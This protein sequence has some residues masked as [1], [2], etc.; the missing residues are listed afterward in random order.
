[1]YRAYRKDN[2]PLRSGY[3]FKKLYLRRVQHEG[4]L[5]TV[6]DVIAE[7]NSKDDFQFKCSCAIAQLKGES[8]LKKIA[9]NGK[10]VDASEVADSFP[11]TPSGKL[12]LARFRENCC[13]KTV[14]IHGQLVTPESVVNDFLAIN[15]RLELARFRQECCER[16][17]PINGRPVSTKSVV[18]DFLAINAQLELARFKQ[19]CCFE[20]LPI[21]GQQVST[22]EVIDHT[23]AAG[24]K[25]GVICFRR[26]C[27]FRELPIAGQQVTPESVLNGFQKLGA[28]LEVARFLEECYWKGISVEHGPVSAERVADS[29]QVANAHLELA[30]FRADCCLKG[31]LLHNH[32]VSP[33]VV[34]DSFPAN[35][36]G[37]SALARFKVKCCLDGFLLHGRPISPEE[38]FSHFPRHQESKMV[39]AHFLEECFLRN[40][41]V[42]GQLV[43]AESVLLS[44]PNT[45]DGQTSLARFRE[46][47]CLKGL[48]ISG[49]LVSPESVMSSFPDNRKG[50]ISRARFTEKCAIRGLWLFGQPI[51]THDVLMGYPD[52]PEGR[53]AAGRFQEDCLFK[54]LM[55]R[56][57]ALTAEAVF[58]ALDEHALAKA[59]FQAECCLRSL[60]LHGRP[61][62]PDTVVAAYPKN[63]D[64]QKQLSHFKRQCCLNNLP[65]AG[66][67]VQP[68]PLVYELE[69]KNMLLE[70]ACFYAELALQA[71]KLNGKELSNDQVLDAFNQLK[72]DYSIKKVY[73]LMQRLIALPELDHRQESQATFEQAWQI[74]ADNPLKDERFR[75]QRCVLLFLAMKHALPLADQPV[76]P[77]TVWQS[78]TALRDSFGNTRLQ[79]YF[80]ADCYF[81]DT[82][83]DGQPVS[84]QQ[85]LG[86]LKKLLPGRLR[87][88]LSCWFEELCR[89]PCKT[90]T[91]NRVLPPPG[92]AQPRP[93]RRP[94][95]IDVH[96]KGRYTGGPFP[97]EVVEHFDDPLR[98][99]PTLISSQTRKAL[100][101]IRGMRGLCLTGSFSRWLQG[102]GSSFNDIDMMASRETITTLV[103]HLTKQLGNQESE[104]DISCKV[105]AREAPGCPQLHL[106]PMVTITLSE[107]DLGQKVSVLQASVYPPD[108]IDNLNTITAAIP[109]EHGTISCLTYVAEVK[110]LND[111]LHFL[112]DQLDDLTTQLLSGPGFTIPRTILFNYPQHRQECVFALLMRC[113]LTLNKAKQFTALLACSDPAALL[114]ELRTRGR[115]LH[116]RLLGHAHR[117]PFIAAL[118]HWLARPS[119]RNTSLDNKRTFIRSLLAMVSNPAEL[120]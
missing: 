91:L 27:F 98:L 66:K 118:T 70:K 95:R 106:N 55:V 74:L 19:F 17:I 87:L 86:S 88:A 47:C 90:D 32:P 79:F 34:I 14:P 103:A 4:R 20:L 58:K 52:T 111:T 107:G 109:G 12:A 61:V 84:E 80:L 8:C 119:P 3:F 46:N 78:I 42:N 99:D 97:Y 108:T 71:R 36:Q 16:E 28:R 117:E 37:R 96:I 112:A 120:F 31:H 30:R 56:G 94:K 29:F 45:P 73:F 93:S 40:I 92:T 6:D 9:I 7:F 23:R 38:V 75:Y 65:L 26:E 15:A 11:D 43:T 76:T 81:A 85:V 21:D 5:I 64:G 53:L 24:D 100:G 115:S 50:R 116:T 68:E 10:P 60:P 77:D 54:G 89:R 104:A 25:L 69:Q 105:L 114:P 59:C 110:L 57:K 51:G 22:K 82:A 39:K 41:A 63:L 83:L 72:I 62:T 13:L 1:M 67:S 102:V 44:F 35:Y 101:I 18:N 33:E 113:L 49:R 2:A 48:R